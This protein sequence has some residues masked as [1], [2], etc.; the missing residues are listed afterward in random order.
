MKCPIRSVGSVASAGTGVADNR[1]PPVWVLGL[2]HGSSRR[3]DN[4]LNPGATSLAF[5]PMILDDGIL[6]RFFH[7]TS[8]RLKMVSRLLLLF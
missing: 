1:E 6:T 7:L 5:A 8:S 3:T 2:E 4:A